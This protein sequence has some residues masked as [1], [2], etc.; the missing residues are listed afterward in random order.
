MN[1]R[2]SAVTSPPVAN[3]RLLTAGKNRPGRR[4]DPPLGEAGHPKRGDAQ[5]AHPRPATP[6]REAQPVSPIRASR[7]G[8]PFLLGE[9]HDLRLQQLRLGRCQPPAAASVR[10]HQARARGA[11]AERRG[12]HGPHAAGDGRPA[13]GRGAAGRHADRGAALH[14]QGGRD[15]ACFGHVGR[16]RNR[17]EPERPAGAL[18]HPGSRRPSRAGPDREQR[19]GPGLQRPGP[20]GARRG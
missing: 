4:H 16:D 1:K 17:P 11:A 8:R 5:R 9:C 3:G 18:L 2:G 6:R 13:D 14:P 12:V 19:A 15:G 10:L 20:G 7:K